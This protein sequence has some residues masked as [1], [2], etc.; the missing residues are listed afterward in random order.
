MVVVPFLCSLLVLG[1]PDKTP[2]AS[3]SADPLGIHA[4]QV[5][6]RLGREQFR[7]TVVGKEG[8]TLTI[9]TAAH[10]VSDRDAGAALLLRHGNTTLRGKVIQAAHNPDYKPVPSRDPASRAVRGVLCVDTALATIQLDPA[11]PKEREAASAITVAELSSEAVVG[12]RIRTISVHIIDQEEREHMV[13]AG[14][15]LN[16]KC[17]AWGRA[18]YH[19]QPGDSGAGV[20]FLQE[21]AGGKLRPVL[22]GNVALSDDRGGIAPVV[23]HSS[24]WVEEAF[25]KANAPKPQ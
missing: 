9:L 5:T 20:F 4:T 7:A 24:H 2:A 19:P 3:A 14:N 11:N 8:E 13:T 15:H 16:P 25:V 6:I 17:L 10:C 22:V 1:L 12:T 21:G 18:S 23:S